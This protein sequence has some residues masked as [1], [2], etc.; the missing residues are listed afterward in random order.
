ML[1]GSAAVIKYLL[2]IFNFIFVITGIAILTVGAVIQHEYMQYEG[3]LNNGYYSTPALFIAIGVIIFI[4]S[5]FGCC[6][7]IKENY[8][9]VLTFAT[10]MIVIFILELAAGIAGYTLRNKAEEFKCCGVDNPSDWVTYSPGLFNATKA[11]PDS[12]CLYAK[13]AT[14]IKT[15]SFES[16][17]TTNIF[18]VG[19]LPAL[20]EVIKAN[21]V[22]LGGAGIGIAVVQL[23]GVV[24]SCT[25]AKGI[26]QEY[27]TV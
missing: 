9:M 19:C 3:L 26:K 8:C 11:W 23:L 2:F 24:L 17:N 27:E 15:C 16:G 20:E 5:F 1:S 25:L 12:C 21:A 18:I 22:K 4:V 6:G 13:N 10:L 14:M 7:S